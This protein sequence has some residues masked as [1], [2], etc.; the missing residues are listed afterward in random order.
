M[1][2]KIEEIFRASYSDITEKWYSYMESHKP[3]LDDAYNA[4]Q[5]AIKGGDNNAIKEAKAVYERTAKNITVNNDRFQAISDELAEKIAHVNEIAVDYVN[6]NMAKVYAINYNALG[7]QNLKGYSF[8]LTN[9]QAVKNLARSKKLMLPNKTVN[10]AKDMRWN[11]KYIN[12]QMMQGI[13]QGES[14][15]QL[16]KRILPEI[17]A[18]TDFTGKTSDEIKGLLK[19]NID[20]SKRNA[21]TMTTAAENKGRQDSFQ[22]ASDD[23]VILS[24][25]WIATGDDRTRDWHLELDGVE[26]AVDEPW[27]NEYGSIM[28]P[29]DPDADPANVYNCRC[30]IRAHVIGFKKW[31]D[32]EEI[33]EEVPATETSEEAVEE[34]NKVVEEETTDIFTPATTIEEAEDYA[35]QNFVVDS[36]WAGEGDVSFKGISLDIANGIN[37]ELTNLFNQYELPK[38]RNMGVM[39]FRQKIWKDAKDAPMAYRNM[40]NGE[41]F[42]NPNILKSEK[43]LNKYITDGQDAFNFCINNMDKFTGKQLELVQRYK[44]AGRQTVADSSDNPLKAMLDHEFGHH[45][46]HQIIL[47][48][49]EFAQVTKDGMN[50]YG[51]K[52]SGYALH[53]RGEYVAESFSAYNNDLGTIDPKLAKIFSGVVKK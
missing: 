51:I 30:S 8:S 37:E 14:I 11:E 28:Y 7:E 22:K 42:F 53:T 49:K 3:G 17:N 40:F 1:E 26:V 45:I 19:R 23:G 20:A 25:E 34:T 6:D 21:R 43:A 47:K 4:L 52:L 41:L 48:D 2:K 9:E 12:S 33:I 31:D 29:G 50:D 38:F 16:S 5:D 39:N 10:V 18:K 32:E 46:D 13:L 36:K 15:P 27:E 35:R 44:E 24:R